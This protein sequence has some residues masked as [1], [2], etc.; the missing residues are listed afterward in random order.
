MGGLMEFF[1]KITKID[2]EKVGYFYYAEACE[3]NPFCAEQV[4]G[5]FLVS[6][7]LVA[8]LQDNP[9]IQ[10]VDWASMK[11]IPANES[12]LKPAPFPPEI[13]NNVKNKQ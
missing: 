3:F 10:K 5:T 13:N 12:N 7:S 8:E 4:D 2:A 6:V 1:Y 9:N 11:I